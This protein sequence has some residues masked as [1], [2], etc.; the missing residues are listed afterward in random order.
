MGLQPFAHVADL[1]FPPYEGAR[2]SKLLHQGEQWGGGGGG[3][4]QERGDG[5]RARN[6]DF[7][8][9]SFPWKNIVGFVG[10]Y[11]CRATCVIITCMFKGWPRQRPCFPTGSV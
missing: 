8:S 11:G 4:K 3:R 2:R 5:S 6:K 9:F 10:S 1:R 7:A